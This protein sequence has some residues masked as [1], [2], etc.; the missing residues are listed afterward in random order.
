MVKHFLSTDNCYRRSLYTWYE[1]LI[2]GYVF[3]NFQNENFEKKMNKF[4]DVENKFRGT[5]RLVQFIVLDSQYVV[6]SLELDDHQK[7]QCLSSKETKHQQAFFYGKS[8]PGKKNVVCHSYNIHN[9][10]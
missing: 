6:D 7:Q 5:F 2:D 3:V 4:M 1:L 9:L 8:L 10:Q